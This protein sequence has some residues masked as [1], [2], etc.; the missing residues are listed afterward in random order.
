[1]IKEIKQQK[2]SKKKRIQLGN[3]E[4][5]IVYSWRYRATLNFLKLPEKLILFVNLAYSV[6]PLYVKNFLRREVFGFRSKSL[7]LLPLVLEVEKVKKSSSLRP[8]LF[9]VILCTK[10]RSFLSLLLWS[11]SRFSILLC[12]AF[13]LCVALCVIPFLFRDFLLKVYLHIAKR[14]YASHRGK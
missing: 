11:D 2:C 1:M 6:P 14:T 3:M 4:T 8:L 12:V 13:L 5:A 7:F 9:V 10:M